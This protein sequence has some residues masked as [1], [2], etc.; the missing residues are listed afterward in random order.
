MKALGA[1]SLYR[2]KRVA[3]DRR[4]KRISS[5]DFIRA[6]WTVVRSAPGTIAVNRIIRV[7]TRKASAIHG[8]VLVSDNV[9]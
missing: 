1:T 7:D 2:A 6:N 5:P 8:E 4:A 9:S 3:L